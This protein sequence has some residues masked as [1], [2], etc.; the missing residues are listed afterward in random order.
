MNTRDRLNSLFVRTVI[1]ASSIVLVACTTVPKTDARLDAAHSSFNMLQSK[2]SSDGTTAPV[3]LKDAQDALAH[4]DAALAERKDAAEIDHKVYLAQQRVAIAEQAYNRKVAEK[5]LTEQNA[6][7]DKMRLAARTAE[8]DQAQAALKDLQ[9]KMTDRGMVMTLGDVLFDVDK[10]TLKSGGKRMVD[11]LAAY[12]D[13]NPQRTVSI[14][15]FTDSTGG[16][17]HNQTLSERRAEAVE[18]ALVNAGIS[19]KRVETQGYGKQ[20][21]VATNSTAAGRQLNRRVEIVLSDENG[22]IPAR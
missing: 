6:D 2:S 12:L 10:A 14:E 22:K 21:P 20:F 3:E 19:S 16:E 4:A 1:G 7:R 15:G 8:A 9:A 11:K 18:A 13:S 17:D 5:A